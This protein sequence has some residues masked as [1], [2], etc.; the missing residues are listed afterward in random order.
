M[1]TADLLTLA[2][3][4][5]A[6]VNRS[7]FTVGIR[8]GLSNR[9]F[10]RLEKG[11]GCNTASYARAVGWFDANWPVDLAWPAHITRPSILAKKG[12]AA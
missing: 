4:Y 5:A 11:L 6:H 12:R 1:N 3:T 2:Q 10:A 7:L 8:A 9:F